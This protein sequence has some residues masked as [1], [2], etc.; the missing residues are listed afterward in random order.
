LSEAT[1]TDLL[2]A[3]PFDYTVFAEP[4]LL[5]SDRPIKL[6]SQEGRLRLPH[7]RD[8]EG[9][10]GL[11]PPDSAPEGFGAHL[12]EGWGLRPEGQPWVELN[13]I[14]VV[15]PV[16]AELNFELSGN[17]IGGEEVQQTLSEV[18]QWFESLIHWLWVST[19]QV[20]IL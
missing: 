6:A 7:D 14:L 20:L 15:V 19:A 12:P 5:G 4:E 8:P 9:N 11:L 13:A 1:E 17:Q 10:L 18:R 16:A 3:I 2:F